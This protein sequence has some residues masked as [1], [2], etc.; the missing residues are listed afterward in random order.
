MN[1]RL[2][3]FLLLACAQIAVPVY[4]IQR[5]ETTLARGRLFKFK[6]VPVDPVDALR[7]RYVAL[8][9][10][11]AA[12]PDAAVGSRQKTPSAPVY[13]TFVEDAAGYAQ[14]GALD[15]L[16]PAPGPGRDA[17]LRVPLRQGWR[18]TQLHQSGPGWTIELPFDRY[19]M[20]EHAA[21]RAEAAYH[22]NAGAGKET[23]ALV[24]IYRG[25][26]AIKDLYVDGAPIEAYRGA[27]ER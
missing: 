10:A 23:Y 7:G 13:A 15:D 3:L 20:E 5:E 25:H 2:L 4:L 11:A 26:A 6:T 16:P 27:P 19:Y 9:F 14:V 12:V 24:A 1:A 22:H 21:P 18:W 8:N 17:T